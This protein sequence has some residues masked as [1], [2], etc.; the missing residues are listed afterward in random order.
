MKNV[1]NFIDWG[2]DDHLLS[3]GCGGAWW[4]INLLF[5]KPCQKII[6]LDRNEEIL[7][8]DEIQSSIQYFENHYQKSF[9]PFVQVS[10]FDAKSTGISNCEL[11][12]IFIFNALHEMNGQKEVVDECFRILKSGGFIL[13]EEDLSMTERKIHSGCEMPLFFQKEL[14]ELF[15]EKGFTLDSLLEKDD[16][17]AYFKFIK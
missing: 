17:A 15:L 13:V 8:T 16:V 7:N 6:L 12:G 3:L 11:D 9:L 5:H 1:L 10:N 2:K 14:I 4:E